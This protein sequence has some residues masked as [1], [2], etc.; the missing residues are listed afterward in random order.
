MD[1]ITDPTSAQRYRCL[2]CRTEWECGPDWPLIAA[3][4]GDAAEPPDECP[5]CGRSA[6][7]LAAATTR[8]VGRG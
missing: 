2:G 8:E 7:A 3:D 4:R 5:E 6:T 1:E